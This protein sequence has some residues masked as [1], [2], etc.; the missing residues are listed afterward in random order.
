[1]FKILRKALLVLAI[2]SL[3]GLASADTISADNIYRDTSL[4]NPD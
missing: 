3:A 2:S 1:M 4:T